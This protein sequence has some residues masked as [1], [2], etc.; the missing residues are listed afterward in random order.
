[1]EAFEP[2]NWKNINF[3]F[4][5]GGTYLDDKWYSNEDIQNMNMESIFSPLTTPI[6][7]GIDSYV[8][9]TWH[10]NG[11]MER[12]TI[13][14]TFPPQMIDNIPPLNIYAQKIYN[15]FILNNIRKENC[16][17]DFESDYSSL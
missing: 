14:S 6:R 1:M 16:S 13:Y 10:N 3:I 8:E 15:Q 11:D 4:P 7:D 2:K 17:Y 9:I 12:K 5:E